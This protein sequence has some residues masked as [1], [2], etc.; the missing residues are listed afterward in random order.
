MVEVDIARGA[1]PTVKAQQVKKYKIFN[2]LGI[3]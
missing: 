1:S 2:L 3:N